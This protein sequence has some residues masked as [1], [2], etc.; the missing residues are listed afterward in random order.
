MECVP[1]YSRTLWYSTSPLVFLLSATLLFL[2]RAP[3]GGQTPE[4]RVYQFLESASGFQLL[5]PVHEGVLES[6][7]NTAVSVTLLEG[8]EYMVVGYCDEECSNLDLTLF[9][10]SGTPL[11]TDHLPDPEPILMWTAES[12]GRHYVQVDVGDCPPEGCRF[13]L[14]FLGSTAE[15][16]VSP[17]EDMAGRLNL[18]GGEFRS[19]G[20]T[21]VGDELRGSLNM[22]QSVFIPVDFEEGLEYRM[23]GVCDKDCF[24]LDLTLRDP[25]GTEVDS[26]RLEDALPILAHIP[27]TTGEY[28]VEVTMVACGI[29]PCAYRIVTYAKGDEVGPGG[30]TF[31]GELIFQETHQGKLAPGD[32]LVPSGEYLDVF[33]IEVRAGQRIIVDLRS[34]DFD[35]L[36]RVL[37]PDGVAEE[38]DDYGE[39]IGHSHIEMLALMDGTYSIHVTSFGPDMSGSYTLQ[40]AIV[41]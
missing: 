40:M 24:D 16:G 5:A 34:E 10:T 25:E 8:A 27:D 33:E 2:L 15:P 6:G 32:D 19:M 23:V 12:T 28:Q 37:P 36:L 22:E 11:L 3:C 38:N 13:A 35:T 1:A 14:G 7:T 18:V 26:D 4:D 21:Q 17:G 30:I 39:D 9:D 20:F 29:E 41:E 31:T